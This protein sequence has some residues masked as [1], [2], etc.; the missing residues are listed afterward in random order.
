MVLL[1]CA[2]C[3]SD[4]GFLIETSD[5]KTLEVKGKLPMERILKTVLVTCVY[6]NNRWDH[7]P[8]IVTDPSID[9]KVSAPRKDRELLN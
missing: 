2:K 1:R 3:G 6:C 5:R 4:A 9:E 7:V 8:V